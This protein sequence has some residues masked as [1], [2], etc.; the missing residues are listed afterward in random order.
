MG[1]QC[2]MNCG[3]TSHIGYHNAGV[4]SHNFLEVASAAVLYRADFLRLP[5]TLVLLV[6]PESCRLESLQPAPERAGRRNSGGCRKL[7]AFRANHT[8]QKYLETHG[9]CNQLT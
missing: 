5:L 2:V 4:N 7:S 6:L 3:Q 8:S 1:I 9:C